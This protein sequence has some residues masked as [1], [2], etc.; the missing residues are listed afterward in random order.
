MGTWIELRCEKRGDDCYSAVNNG[1]MDM[2]GDTIASVL[3]T[4]SILAK[5]ARAAGWKKTREGWICPAC[6]GQLSPSTK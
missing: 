6:A 4:L 5:E 2:A 3:D 1:P